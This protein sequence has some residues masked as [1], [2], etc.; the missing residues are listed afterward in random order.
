MRKFL[1][2]DA[3]KVIERNR[4]KHVEQYASA[5]PG[6]RNLLD[7]TYLAQLTQMM[8][9]GEAWE[10]FRHLFK[11]KR[12]LEDLVKAVAPVRND[13]AHFR[14]V[15]VLELRRCQIA[16]EDLRTLLSKDTAGA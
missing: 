16:C 11:D 4:D 14:A 13:R 3:W 1:G 10:L 2:E 12:Q 15:P 7:Y 9:A 8:L 5:P 6:E